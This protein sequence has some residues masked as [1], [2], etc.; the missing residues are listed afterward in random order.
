MIESAIANRP[1]PPASHWVKNALP[2]SPI[3]QAQVTLHFHINLWQP[4][5]D[6][7]AAGNVDGSCRVEEDAL[8]QSILIRDRLLS[9]RDDRESSLTERSAELLGGL[10]RQ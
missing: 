10:T 4:I 6:V 5:D 8:S 9:E 7:D 1:R 3:C 2:G